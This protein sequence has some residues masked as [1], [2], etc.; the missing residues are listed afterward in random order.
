MNK[1]ASIILAVAFISLCFIT[2]VKAQGPGF[3]DGVED[4]P[5]DGGVTLIAAAAIGYGAKK[6]SAARSKKN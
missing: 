6:L 1:R 5:I 3:D 4:T 2:N